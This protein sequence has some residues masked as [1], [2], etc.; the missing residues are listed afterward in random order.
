VK[1]AVKFK[2]LLARVSRRINYAGRLNSP[3][4]NAVLFETFS[5]KQIG[6]S[7]LAIAMELQKNH[8]ELK[9][10]W[11]TTARNPELP[12]GMTALRHGSPTWYRALATS[13]FLV[14]N[15]NFP[16]YFRKREGQTYL[17]TWHGT[18]LKMIGQ[19][20][21]NDRTS[22]VYQQ[23]MKRESGFWD[24]LISPSA[25]CTEIF[26]KAFDSKAKVLELGYPRNDSLTN[27]T[28]ETRAAIRL[29][30]GVTEPNQ[31]LVLYAPTWR[32]NARGSKGG[33]ESV[34]YL[35]HETKLP[36][37]FTLLYRGH[38]N[39]HASH[40]PKNTPELI[41]VT[42][43]PNISDLFIAADVLV[44]D[45]SSVMF[46]FSVTGKPM[47]FLTPDLKVYETDRGFY[48]DFR[49][50]A[51]GPICSTALEVKQ[52]L[53]D[54]DKNQARYAKKYGAWKEKFN[55]KDDGQAAKRAVN[56]V[57]K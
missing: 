30:L 43:Y 27:A 17:Q 52:A 15:A 11:S 53:M 50:Q 22:A 48:F 3:L 20:I 7:P 6:D 47:I 51:P 33:W 57:W 35:S 46:D 37:G 18:P 36:E 13:K 9:L 49:A 38:A 2:N 34:T 1:I 54:L 45:Y 25:Y 23:T 24:Y 42:F 12:E 19:D 10:Y 41:D 56:A 26:P 5:G 29:K 32:D 14:N 21:R 4:K 44:T 31:M 16:S 8:P 55:P 40:K 28:Q 39:T